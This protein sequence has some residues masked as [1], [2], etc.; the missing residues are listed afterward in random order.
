MP[1]EALAPSE[2]EKNAAD[3][4]EGLELALVQLEYLDERFPTGTTPTVISRLVGLIERV[5]PN[6]S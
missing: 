1:S 5:K 3:F 2:C 4:L 6:G